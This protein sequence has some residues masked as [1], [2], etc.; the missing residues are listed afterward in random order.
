MNQKLKS[1]DPRRVEL[2]IISDVHLGTYGSQAR[3]LEQYLRS[4]RPKTL[5]LNGDIIDIW[6]FSKKYWPSSHMKIVKRIFS[7]L[8]KKTDVYFIPGNHDEMLRKFVGTRLGRLKVQNKVVLNLKEE[9]VWIFHGDA[10]DVTM[11]H[12]RWLAKLGAIGYDLLI[13]LN[14]A[15]NKVLQAAGKSRISFAGK[16]KKSVKKAV[17]FVNSFEETV[18]QIA[19]DQGFDTVVCGHIHQPADKFI[20]VNNRQIRYLNSGDWIENLTA[21]EYNEGCWNLYRHLIND[22]DA[23]EKEPDPAELFSE[24]KEELMFSRNFVIKPI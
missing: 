24:M 12:S 20:S 16:I 3:A 5:I 22:D 17:S 19:A 10:F 15:V 9:K 2:V 6:Q 21:L 4:V 13:L 14:S 11:Q 23:E 7:L 1:A 8:S 18:A